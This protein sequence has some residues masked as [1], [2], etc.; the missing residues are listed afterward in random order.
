MPEFSERE[1]QKEQEHWKSWTV[2]VMSASSNENKYAIDNAHTIGQLVAK[3][4]YDAINGGYGVG[5]MGAFANGFREQCRTMG[6]SDDEITQHLKGVVFSEKVIGQALAK[7][8]TINETAT[9]TSGDSLAE[10]A[11][12]I[13]K[14]S[15][16]IIAVEGGLGTSVEALMAAQDEWFRE[17]SEDKKLPT[18][19]L[20]LI[21]S[22]T[23]IERTIEFYEKSSPK[24]IDG[25]TPHIYVLSGHSNPNINRQA[26][27]LDM[28]TLKNDPKM[29][30][31]LE[32]LL[33]MY[34]L[35]SLG[36]EVS[37]EQRQREQELGELLLKDGS[38]FKVMTIKEK[39]LAKQ[40]MRGEGEGI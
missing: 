5:G 10:R 1:P 18:R 13:I 36:E 26:G 2:G 14:G 24:T 33:E 15:D 32:M 37:V 25:L 9:I 17:R 20:I 16:A 22:T 39:L 34:Y 27:E 11:G 3:N 30:K 23:M 35:R 28:A 7:K 4:G 6:F 38:K 31:Q 40:L 12:K 8:R 29:A 21:E 19:P